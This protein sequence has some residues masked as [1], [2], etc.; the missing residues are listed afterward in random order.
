MCKFLA[1]LGAFFARTVLAILS[2]FL[3]TINVAP[4]VS[5]Q[6]FVVSLVGI[7]AGLL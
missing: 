4:W 1:I 6:R 5:K 3:S 7:D 2:A